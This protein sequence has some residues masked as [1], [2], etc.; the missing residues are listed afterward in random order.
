MKQLVITILCL[1]CPWFAM[2][3][4]TVSPNG[5]IKVAT[6][7]TQLI[8][9]HQGASVLT[10]EGVRL[11]AP[12]SLTGTINDDYQMLA[13]KKLHCQNRAKMYEAP[14]EGGGRFVLRV[15]DNGIAFRY[16]R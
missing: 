4:Q 1:L 16:V 12:L 6:K 10:I 15:Y 11:T 2:A 8:V 3:K 13:G 9:R 14:I 5:R 7:G